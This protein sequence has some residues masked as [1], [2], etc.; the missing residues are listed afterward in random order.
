MGGDDLVLAQ[1]A[2][3]VRQSFGRIEQRVEIVRPAGRGDV[4]MNHRRM[5][6]RL[7]V[8]SLVCRARV[9]VR[10]ARQIHSCQ[11]RGGNER[12]RACDNLPTREFRHV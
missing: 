4:V 1:A 6:E 12:R 3:L 9:P 8:V 5:A 11:R 10:V 2:V 7:M